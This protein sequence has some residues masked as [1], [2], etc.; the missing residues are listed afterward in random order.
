MRQYVTLYVSIWTVDSA[1]EEHTFPAGSFVWE[2]QAGYLNNLESKTVAED[3]NFI[4]LDYQEAHTK[5]YMYNVQ[6]LCTPY[7]AL[8]K[9]ETDF[10]TLQNKGRHSTDPWPTP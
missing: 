3:T 10:K 8:V 7:T 2:L 9:D 5:T 4:S 1:L 6:L